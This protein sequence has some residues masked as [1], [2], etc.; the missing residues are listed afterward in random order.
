MAAPLLEARGLVVAHP[1]RAAD[2]PAACGPIDLV[3][4]SGGFLTI[5][6]GNGSGKS[7]LL[8]TLA[9]LVAPLAG[10]V[11][12]GGRDPFAA[13]TRHAAR[14]EVGVVF[15]EPETQHLT[16]AVER[17]IA[18]PLEN[19]GWPRAEI[20]ARVEEVLAALGLEGVRGAAPAHLSGGEA[21]RLALAAALA[22]RPRLLLLDEPASYLD[23]PGRAALVVA[24]ESLR[25]AGAAIVWSACAREESPEPGARL[26]L[27]GGAAEP[28]SPEPTLAVPAGAAGPTL[29]EGTGLA[30]T[31]RDA[32]GSTRIWGGL[33]LHIAAGERVV[34]LGDNGSGK[35]ALLDLL[36]GLVPTRPEDGFEGTLVPPG[37]TGAPPLRLRYL[38][39]YPESQLF[40]PTVAA[41]RDLW[42]PRRSLRA[43]GPRRR[44]PRGRGSRSDHGAGPGARGAEHRG[45]PPRR[46]GR[47]PGGRS[48]RAPARRTHGRPG[49]FGAP[50]P[51]AGARGLVLAHPAGGAASRGR[52]LVL[53]TH[54]P[55]WAARPGWRTLRLPDPRRVRSGSSGSS[56]SRP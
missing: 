18:F 46:P 48:G 14:L 11:R 53:A 52:T 10:T 41:G 17:E 19:L 13:A 15:Q 5:T 21:Q 55:V 33:D 56:G 34:L 28:A 30:L 24:L 36:A 45:A 25:A 32:R 31:R 35:T 12:I 54:D 44:R 29:W 4:E 16:D 50:G 37:A 3:V 1:G 23:P 38:T 7:A 39:Q 49:L 2:E 20:T 6:G 9:G 27:G 40:A 8:A 42:R 43:A 47:R 26:D 22:P 51:G